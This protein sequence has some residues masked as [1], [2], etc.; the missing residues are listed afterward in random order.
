MLLFIPPLYSGGLGGGS[1]TTAVVSMNRE[2]RFNPNF[3][4]DRSQSLPVFPQKTASSGDIRF[5]SVARIISF[6]TR[7]MACL[8]VLPVKRE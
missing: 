8:R 6:A 2:K 7:I 3:W 5:L 1:W 4:S